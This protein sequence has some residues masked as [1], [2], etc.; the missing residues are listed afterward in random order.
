MNN[1]LEEKIIKIYTEEFKSCKEISKLLNISK[2]KIKRIIKRNNLSRS[3][4][5]AAKLRNNNF[6]K[7]IRTAEHKKTLSDLAKK[8][9][10]DKNPFF[11]KKHTDEFKNKM[12]GLAKERTA[13]RNPN[14]KHG[15]Y[16]RRPRDFKQAEFTRIRNFVFNRD[17]YTCSI[18][19]Y[20]GG[21]LHAHHLLPYW[22]CPEAFLDYDN[23]I[24]VSSEHHFISCH[25][26]NWCK[27]NPNLVPDSLLKKYNLCRERLNEL[28]G[29][30]PE[31]IVRPT[32]INETVEIDRNVQSIE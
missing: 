32:D 20:S 9:T 17:K 7:Y 3:N 28:A 8:R 25:N 19:G 29:I 21:H 14:Y 27:F 10:G 30:H 18:S 11:G 23:L 5:E 1:N 13:K 31:A 15:E 12:S 22:V 4:S 16:Q 26:S 6:G 2:D 24:T